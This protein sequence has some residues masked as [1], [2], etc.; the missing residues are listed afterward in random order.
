MDKPHSLYTPQARI[1]TK[2]EIVYQEEM[3]ALVVD[4]DKTDIPVNCMNTTPQYLQDVFD[5]VLHTHRVMKCKGLTT[6]VFLIQKT[7]VVPCQVETN[8]IAN[9]YL[10][11]AVYPQK[12]FSEHFPVIGKSAIAINNGFLGY[13]EVLDLPFEELETKLESFNASHGFGKTGSRKLKNPFGIGKMESI[14]H[15]DHSLEIY[16][17]MGRDIIPQQLKGRDMNEA[18]MRRALLLSPD[19]LYEKSARSRKT[20]RDLYRLA[21]LIRGMDILDPNERITYQMVMNQE[22]FLGDHPLKALFAK[23]LQ[24]CRWGEMMRS[25]IEGN[26]VVDLTTMTAWRVQD[27]HLHH[28]RHFY[29]CR[30]YTLPTLDNDTDLSNFDDDEEWGRLSHFTMTNVY[31]PIPETDFEEELP[32]YPAMQQL[33]SLY[34]A[35]ASEMGDGAVCRIYQ[36]ANIASFLLSS[37]KNF[38]M[39][40]RLPT[41][42]ARTVQYKAVKKILR[43]HFPSGCLNAAKDTNDRRMLVCARR[44][45]DVEP[46]QDIMAS[47][48]IN[49]AETSGVCHLSNELYV[50]LMGNI[51]GFTPKSQKVI[52]TLDGAPATGKSYTA[53]ASQMITN[54][55]GDMQNAY[56][57]CDEHYT[58]TRSHTVSPMNPYENVLGQR[59][60]EEWRSGDGLNNPYMKNVSQESTTMKTMYDTGRSINQRCHKV[61]MPNGM[62]QLKKGNDIALEDRSV[63]ILANG[64]KVCSSIKDRCM[65]FRVPD[66]TAKVGITDRKTIMNTLL[67]KR[68]PEFFSLMRYHITEEFN[69]QELDLTLKYD[70]SDPEIDH[71]EVRLTFE[72]I[73]EVM[74]AWGS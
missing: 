66:L 49:M 12:E 72:R 68:I 62:E 69:R 47:Q 73:H 10:L 32:L 20:Y 61:K 44:F 8:S 65:I 52:T 51:I 57:C 34:K 3:C 29:E 14:Y 16:H 59:F 22:R 54:G 15:L 13:S 43:K 23:H 31:N 58:T 18:W 9:G 60:I 39:S 40:G 2:S 4:I 50:F 7:S 64:F 56:A 63:I 6:D 42:L 67:S 36:D 71:N 26:S 17:F 74:I 55:E 11:L 5:L 1:V 21:N 37:Y 46:H 48:L 19:Y 25:N 38:M 45:S 53:R 27:I 33:K 70:D 24:R 35:V 28:P 30:L 41:S